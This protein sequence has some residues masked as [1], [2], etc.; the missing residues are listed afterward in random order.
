MKY[1][2][3]SLMIELTRYC[4]MTCPHCIRGDRQRRKISKDTMIKVFESWRESFGDYIPTLMFTGGEPALAVDMMEFALE[5][6]IMSGI[7]VGNFWI[8][9]N[10]LIHSKRF[11]NIL[12]RWLSYC[13]DGELNGIRVSIDPYHDDINL[14][15]WREFEEELKEYK[16]IQVYFDY[17]G[18]P[19][20]SQY[21][22]SAGKAEE[23][24]YCTRQVK[25]DAHLYS[26]GEDYNRIEGTTYINYKGDLISTCDISFSLQD[27]QGSEFN[28][29]NI[30]QNS[31]ESMYDEFFKNH[32]EQVD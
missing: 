7:N 30:S 29:G 5:I 8:A 13:E 32:P 15:V 20:D 19:K 3:D 31:L 12:E 25:H 2:P 18:A 26:E 16:G 21:L 24:Y 23:N 27:E 28:L 17:T 4:N 9:T 22:I 6:C 11:F 10:G 1:Q 14:N